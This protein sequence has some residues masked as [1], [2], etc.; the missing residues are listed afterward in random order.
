MKTT[1]QS[2]DDTSVIDRTV[3]RMMDPLLDRRY[4]LY[5]DELYTLDLLSRRSMTGVQWHVV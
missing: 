2:A 4:I 1:R 5:T 3:M